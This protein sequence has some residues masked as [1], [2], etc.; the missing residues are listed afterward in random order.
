MNAENTIFFISDNEKNAASVQSKIMLLRAVDDFVHIDYKNCFEKIKIVA[1]AVVFFEVKNKQNEFLSFM[2]KV[3][4]TPSLKNVSIIALFEKIDEELLCSCFEAGISDFLTLNA[5]DSEFTVRILWAIQKKNR[6]LDFNNKKNIL[7]QLDILDDKTGIYT[8]NYTFTILKEESKK[9][10]G[11]LAVIA[12]DINTRNSFSIEQ[13]ALTVKK[14]IRSSDTIGFAGEFKL[15]VWFPETEEG[16]ILAILEK[17]KKQLPHE[18]TISAG[19]AKNHNEAL[20][21]TEEKANN[22]L[23]RALLK[24][25][26]FAIASEK[27]ENIVSSVLL[28]SSSVTEKS[29]GTYKNFK[30]FK[31]NFYKKFEKIISPIFYQTHKI[32][33]EKFFETKVS[34][35]IKENECY[36]HIKN[37]KCDSNFKINY[38]GYTKINIDISHN[39]DSEIFAN[40]VSMEL[41][42]INGTK[43]T[44]L[45]DEFVKDYQKFYGS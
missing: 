28:S 20:E 6:T 12:A 44:K 5:T 1:P 8:K 14:N 31:Q 27:K 2:N 18:C 16:K 21:L 10:S 19:I 22:A 33:E 7:S 35:E 41:D 11:S 40:K 30:L 26:S 32:I 39:V 37:E 17:I 43:I 13:L 42:E 23:S 34:H 29:D 4:Q 36:F 38:P 24:E 25:N 9:N 45:L 3:N 15:Y